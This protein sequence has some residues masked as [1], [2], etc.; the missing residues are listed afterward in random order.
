M[1]RLIGCLMLLCAHFIQA[2]EVKIKF[3]QLQRDLIART[4]PR[5]DLNDNPCA[6]IRVS[7]ANT[8]EFDFEGNIVGEVIYNRGE[9]LIYITQGSKRMKIRSNEYGVIEYEFPEEIVKQ[10]AYRL[11]IIPLKKDP[12]S[13]E[14]IEEA[15]KVINRYWEIT[16]LKSYLGN[17]MLP[18]YNVKN[19]VKIICKGESITY[20]TQTCMDLSS[21]KMFVKEYG[22]ACGRS[23]DKYW[24]GLVGETVRVTEK[25]E[26]LK[27]NKI[28][29]KLQL[30]QS[31]IKE[32]Y[33][34]KHKPFGLD[35]FDIENSSWVYTIGENKQENGKRYIGIYKRNRNT[36]IATKVIY[37]DAESGL[38]HQIVD[39]SQ[40]NLIEFLKYQQFEDKLLC[41][42]IKQTKNDIEM[43]VSIKEVGFGI[44][45]DNSLLN[46][47]VITKASDFP[48]AKTNRKKRL[49]GSFVEGLTMGIVSHQE[50]AN[51]WA[52]IIASFSTGACLVKDLNGIEPNY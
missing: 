45:F 38:I 46:N 28:T 1:K 3:E 26:P 40:N 10:S 12:F 13:T 32:V 44:S 33:E 47:K 31:K 35:L 37:I 7:A 23:G 5:L 34:S 30:P 17:K 51:K 20:E 6:V 16:G 21:E 18:S 39:H 11:E 43:Y 24:A 19:E 25:E 4:Q 41:S 27:R 48:E 8:N 22:Q 29:K 42:E 2:Q 50:K 15:N 52:S 49:M 9:A 14:A 36:G